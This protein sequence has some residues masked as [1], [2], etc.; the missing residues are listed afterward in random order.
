[1]KN[2]VLTV[3]I[4][5]VALVG[6]QAQ[7]S[8]NLLTDPG[9]ENGTVAGSTIG[10][11]LTDW[12]W[13]G[14]V[15]GNAFYTGDQAKESGVKSAATLIW[16]GA[17][18]DWAAFSKDFT[19]INFTTPYIFSGYFLH[20]VIDSLKNGSS[21]RLQLKWFNNSTELRVDQ[22]AAFNNSFAVDTWNLLSFTSP[23]PPATANKLSAVV[24][25]TT[26]GAYSPDSK[27]FVDDVSLNAVPEPSS[28]LLLGTGL[29]GLLGLRRRKRS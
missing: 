10:S 20:N 26:S 6:L 29:V 23:T 14:G 21:G 5:G 7:A 2:L 8:A 15:S 19:S 13:S 24:A 11:N 28:L 17:S 3:L 18:G 12:T 4:L 9:F 16:G 22:S 25:L 1:M 27:F